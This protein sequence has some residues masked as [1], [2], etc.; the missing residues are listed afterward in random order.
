M[1]LLCF[2]HPP[3]DPSTQKALALPI[4]NPLDRH[5]RILYVLS[6]R[7]RHFCLRDRLRLHD[8]RVERLCA[9]KSY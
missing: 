2:G 9:S 6:H 8:W 4:A 5:G 7:C 1:T 3:V